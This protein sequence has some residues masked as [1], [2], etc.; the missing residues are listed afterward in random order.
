MLQDYVQGGICI[1][2][3]LHE[4]PAVSNHWQIDYLLNSLFGLTV[5]ETSKLH[6]T[7][8]L[9]FTGGFSSQSASDV[10]SFPCHGVIIKQF[11]RCI[12]WGAK[13]L[14]AICLFSLKNQ[15]RSSLSADIFFPFWGRK[16]MAVICRGYFLVTVVVF[17]KIAL[18]CVLKG[19]IYSKAPFV[20]I[21]L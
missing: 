2:M 9:E 5:K 14:S 10:G 20:Q 4:C 7:G 21:M 15:V 13:F 6:I 18:K 1:T 8:P 19:P 16:L 17:I 3:M 11:A 12:D